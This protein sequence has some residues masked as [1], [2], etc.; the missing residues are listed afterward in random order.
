M[1]AN[2]FIITIQK[3]NDEIKQIQK[4]IDTLKSNSHYTITDDTEKDE[5]IHN[6]ISSITVYGNYA[7]KII[8]IKFK[9][10]LVFEII[11]IHQKWYYFYNDGCVSITDTRHLNSTS[12]TKNNF[13]IEV[14]NKNNKLFTED[15]FG[16][17]EFNEFVDMLGKN[18]LLHNIEMPKQIDRND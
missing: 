5:F 6:V 9:V 1:Q 18:K 4:K 16:K 13:M 7:Q 17:Y 15:I 10:N 3:L 11:F 12:A 2:E 14:I 8:E